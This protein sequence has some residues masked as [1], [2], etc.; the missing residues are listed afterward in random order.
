M[1]GV[2]TAFIFIDGM[3]S[4][5]TEV[6]ITVDIA[7]G[8]IA[9]VRADVFSL[10]I[11]SALGGSLIGFYPWNKPPAKIFMGDTGSMF[12]GLLLAAV[13]IARPSKSPVV[14]AIGGASRAR[15]APPLPPPHLSETTF[16]LC[17]WP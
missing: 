7:F 10:V 3:D 16:M 14:L 17:E 2:I 9:I 5:A 11:M 12:I 6:G 15:R 4:L 13:S 8:A 1:D